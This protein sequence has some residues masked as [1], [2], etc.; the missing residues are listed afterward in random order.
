VQSKV[1]A[2]ESSTEASPTEDSPTVEESKSVFERQSSI[3]STLTFETRPLFTQPFEKQ[4]VTQTLKRKA[5]QPIESIFDRKIA[6]EERQ[7]KMANER[8]STQPMTSMKIASNP[9]WKKYMT[10][11]QPRLSM[12]QFQKLNI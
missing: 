1:R 2:E 12:K 10:V 6:E 8:V 5:V 4:K 7:E 11:M 9:K 3:S